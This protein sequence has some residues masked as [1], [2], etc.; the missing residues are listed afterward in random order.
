MI[1]QL[2][3]A[4]LVGFLVI[5]PLLVTVYLIQLIFGLADRFVGYWFTEL[6]LATG[7]AKH[8]GEAIVFLGIPFTGRVPLIGLLLV[9]FILLLIGGLA[10]TVV[11]RHVFRGIERFF[12]FIPVARGVYNTVQQV[13]HAF[14]HEQTTFKQVVLVEYPRKGIYTVGFITGESQG[15]IQTMEGRDYVNVFLPKSPNPTNGWLALVPRE[16]VQYLDL[17]IEDGLKFVIS[18]GVVPPTTKIEQLTDHS[19]RV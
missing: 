9:V 11:G 15:T 14:V 2:R 19:E 17:P 5:L 7:I 1:K 3:Q 10:K 8:Q 16:E 6:L 13:T 4:L 12:G 18:G